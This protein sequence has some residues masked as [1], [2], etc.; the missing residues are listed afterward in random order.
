MEAFQ[1]LI[2]KGANIQCTSSEGETLLTHAACLGHLD[3]IKLLVEK[4]SVDINET[5]FEG[6]TALQ[7]GIFNGDMPLVKLLVQLGASIPDI[8][9]N[10]VASTGHLGLF[11]TLH[12]HVHS[13]DAQDDAGRFPLYCAIQNNK[14]RMA[15][16][17]IKAGA[18]LHLKVILDFI[19]HGPLICSWYNYVSNPYRLSVGLI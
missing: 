18:K 2:S 6:K 16:E 13:L 4:H 14:L 7:H 10:D 11:T 3:I 1:Y 8:I 19:N 5:G 15:E 9:M 17:L 12:E